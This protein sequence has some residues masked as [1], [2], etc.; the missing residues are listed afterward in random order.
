MTKR[1]RKLQN[2]FE[3]DA[4]IQLDVTKE[5][6]KGAESHDSS[7]DEDDCPVIVE[8]NR[9][10][11][12]VEPCLAGNQE[13]EDEGF[14]DVEICNNLEDHFGHDAC[15]ETTGENCD[16]SGDDIWDDDKIPDPLSDD[17]QEEAERPFTDR[18]QPD[19]LLALHKTFNNADEFKYALLRYSLK[20]EYDIK[21][22]KSSSN[23]LWAKCTQHIE[24]KCPWMVYCSFQ[25]SKSKLVISTFRNEHVCVRSGY[26]K[27]LKSG[28]ISQ[29][30]EERLRVNP[31]IK[32]Q[33]MVDEIKREYNMIVTVHQ[34]RRA[35]KLLRTKRRAS[36]ES[37]FARI[38]DYQEEIHTSNDGSTMEIETI[39]GPIPGGLQRFY[40]LYVCFEAS[41]SSWRQS[42]RPII[43]L[44]AAF[45][46]W[47]IK[48]QMLAAVGRDGDNRIFPIAWAVV[49]VE[50]IDNWMWFVRLLK[51]DLSL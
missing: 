17:D 31:K 30:Y 2:Q 1:K 35:K 14:I 13:E 43:G 45:M 34:C 26:T 12:E 5:R 18:V 28:T 24:E 4:R 40:R 50:D 29:L 48:G 7:D 42:C 15:E 21:M 38:L 19:D 33:E 9:G 8:D 39:P 20:T 49:E 16:D 41:K 3:R 25:K 37:H 46:K 36:H 32:S 47:D 51:K 6:V 11:T 27:L 44:D 10:Y 23:R 22:F